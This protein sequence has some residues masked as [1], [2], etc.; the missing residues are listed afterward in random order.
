[1]GQKTPTFLLLPITPLAQSSDTSLIPLAPPTAS[2]PV[3]KKNCPC[4]LE[5]SMFTLTAFTG[6]TTDTDWLNLVHYIT[7]TRS[8]A[9]TFAVHVGL[10]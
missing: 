1:M 4:L 2:T 8:C 10:K 7:S 5:S 3:S 6:A 9:F